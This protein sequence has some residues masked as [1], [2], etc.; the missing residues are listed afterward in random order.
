MTILEKV[1]EVLGIQSDAGGSG[2]A[3]ILEHVT[4]LVNNPQTGG[5]Q[6]LVQ[7]F[8]NKGLGDVV[9]SW[10]SNGANQPISG[11]QV[12]QV[13]GQDRLAAIASKVGMQPDQISGLIAQHLPDVIDKLTPSG[14]VA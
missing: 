7:Q 1:T 11:D 5:L 3:A 4:A 13:V 6:G 2:N 8:Q 14:K 10:I 12:A 9:N